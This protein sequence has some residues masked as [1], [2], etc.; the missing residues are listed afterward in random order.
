[1]SEKVPGSHVLEGRW[2][3]E[4]HAIAVPKGREAGLDFLRGF[5]E[6]IGKSGLVHD[7]AERA[8]LKGVITPGG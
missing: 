4:R 5:T 6:E 3:E 8:G 2:G 7:A 1:M